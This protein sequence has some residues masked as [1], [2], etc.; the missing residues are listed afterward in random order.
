MEICFPQVISIHGN[1]LNFEQILDRV[2]S[3]TKKAN[4]KPKKSISDAGLSNIQYITW[5]EQFKIITA[6]ITFSHTF[7]F[8]L[9]VCRD[10][11]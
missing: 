7:F 6:C 8:A 11:A 10:C 3:T 9:E 4:P 2:N 1:V 5:I